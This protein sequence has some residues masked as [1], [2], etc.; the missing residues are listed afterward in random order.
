MPRLEFEVVVDAPREAVWAFYDDVL[1]LPRI[2][3]PSTRVRLLTPPEPMRE[4]ARY[5]LQVIQP[6]LPLPVRWETVIVEYRAPELFVD[7]QG[8][9][10]PFSYWRHEHHFE[11]M[12][13]GD[14]TLL[15]DRV[16]YDPPMGVLGFVADE[17]FLRRQ[18]TAM[19]RYH[20]KKT[21]EAFPSRRV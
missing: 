19:F 10:G 5:M 1:T 9:V 4:G 8:A 14:R 18:F 21:Q 20:H 3:P 6:P 12:P 16:T 13:G 2:T 7:E 17:L 11:E 15:R